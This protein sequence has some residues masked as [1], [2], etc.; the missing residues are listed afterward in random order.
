MF[1]QFRFGAL[2]LFS[3]SHYWKL[4]IFLEHFGIGQRKEGKKEG[5]GS[6]KGGEGIKKLQQYSWQVLICMYGFLARYGMHGIAC[7][8]FCLGMGFFP[9]VTVYSS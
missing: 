7:G 6:K 3:L 8:C 4:I 5:G 9:G 2:S 1:F